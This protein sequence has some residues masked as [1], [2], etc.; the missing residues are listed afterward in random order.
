ML[1]DSEIVLSTFYQIEHRHLRRLFVFLGLYTL[2]IVTI[3]W[4]G[5]ANWA[6]CLPFYLVA[7]ASLHG[8]SL[9]TH[10]GV[11]G[12]LFR[13]R[14]GNRILSIL[15]AMPVLQNFTAYKVLHLEHHSHL[16]QV[17]DPD[18]YRNYT[19]WSQLEFLMYWGRLLVG[20]PV[21]IVMIPILAWRQ[22]KTEERS[23][24]AIELLLLL[25]S[26]GII[27]TF[28]PG[29]WLVQGWLIP[30]AVINVMV[31]IRGM[32]QHTLL[33][34]EDDVI[35][36]TRTLISNPVTRFFMCNENYHLEHH[37]YP[38]VPWY[39]L[40]RLHQT[41]YA[42]LTHRGAPYLPSYW[43]FVRQFIVASVRK[44]S[45]GSVSI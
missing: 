40:P 31:N 12:L 34:H 39:H 42:E 36:G 21:Y 3:I 18:R 26:A 6:A 20:Y 9:F 44:T 24:M 16:G 41:V 14:H 27:C 19:Q 8:I 30:M 17:G 43:A 23:W 37:L 29:S 25:T 1:L 33:E 2:S 4:L 10:E 7:A 11:H 38:G 35:R 5:A 13:N 28:V 15:C 45:V 32:S 22:A